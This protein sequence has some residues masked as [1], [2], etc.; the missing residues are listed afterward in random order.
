MP[1]KRQN[2]SQHRS[3]RKTAAV[4]P[5]L[6]PALSRLPS[7][8]RQR[9][10]WAVNLV[11]A[12]RL[13]K[14]PQEKQKIQTAMYAFVAHEGFAVIGGI[15]PYVKTHPSEKAPDRILRLWDKMIFAA[16]RKEKIKVT[17]VK[18]SLAWWPLK[19]RYIE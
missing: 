19:N 9:L 14:D 17:E 2:Q 5:L 4:E 11:E 16:L 8:S 3:R 15:G 12:G 6:L 13:P 1:L 10:E 18:S 7:D